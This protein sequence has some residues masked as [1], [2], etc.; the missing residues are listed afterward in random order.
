MNAIDPALS[1]LIA[2]TGD[3]VRHTD[4]VLINRGGATDVITSLL[5]MAWLQDLLPYHLIDYRPAIF[6]GS[7]G[8]YPTYGLVTP[9][10]FEPGRPLYDPRELPDNFEINV[11]SY[12]ARNRQEARDCLV[13]QAGR[14]ILVNQALTPISI[15]SVDITS[16]MKIGHFRYF[17]ESYLSDEPGFARP[18]NRNADESLAD[19]VL[20]SSAYPAFLG[21]YTTRKG[22]RHIDMAF[23]EGHAADLSEFAL[24]HRQ[25]RGRDV[26]CIIFGNNYLDFSM[27][28]TDPLK[29]AQVQKHFPDAI[30]AFVHESLV[31][32]CG[33]LFGADNVFDLSLKIPQDFSKKSALILPN[34]FRRDP[35]AISTRMNWT[36]R[37]LM[38][39]QD[40][41][42]KMERLASAIK[43]RC[44]PVAAPVVN[45]PP[46]PYRGKPFTLQV[47][48][49]APP[50]RHSYTS[51]FLASATPAV[52]LLGEKVEPAIDFTRAT[53]LPFA[54]AVLRATA[55]MLTKAWDDSAPW[56]T[57]QLDKL[58]PPPPRHQRDNRGSLTDAAEE[59]LETTLPSQHR[60]SVQRTPSESGHMP[61]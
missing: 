3:D 32:H 52:Q 4:I 47:E 37:A 35:E 13:A 31:N 49:S 41:A 24:A 23:V 46:A 11:K 27:N 1:S 42:D 28:E 34:A 44:L 48:D 19:A 33:I 30:R 55:T 26:I 57:R 5:N 25:T 51:E 53:L 29:L 21:D 10:P 60:S 38:D 9:S 43:E 61:L 36:R 45:F 8:T 39:S 54:A 16:Q 22:T 15:S 7:A 12:L 50:P 14:D 40:H 59:R 56:R 2:A 6:A 58:L 17:P 20:A 18:A